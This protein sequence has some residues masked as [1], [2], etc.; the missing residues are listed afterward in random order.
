M[1]CTLVTPSLLNRAGTLATGVLLLVAWSA[2]CTSSLGMDLTPGNILRSNLDT[3]VMAEYTPA[4][5]LVQSFT[6]PDPDGDNFPDLRDII[7]DGDGLVHAYHGTFTPHLNTLDPATST[8]SDRTIAGWSTTNNISYGGVGNFG[9]Y[10]FATDMATGG[11]GTPEGIVRFDLTGGATVRFADSESYQDLTIGGDGLVYGL[12]GNGNTIDVFQPRDLSSVRSIAFDSELQTADVRGIAV[13]S[14]GQI[15][16]AAWDGSIY[17]ADSDGNKVDSISSR[18]GSLTDIDLDNE[19]NLV[20]G[21]RF[22]Q[23]FLTDVLL[24]SITSFAPDT[25]TVHVAFTSPLQVPEPSATA[26]VVTPLVIM[27]LRRRRTQ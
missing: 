16:A 23:V 22:G 19:G 25:D 8:Y 10:V 14:A 15:Y 5:V 9:N 1:N 18:E 24:N 11:A 21:G 7:V 13:S 3:G 12:R 4:G 27:V 26:L 17:A 20:V 6:F 2:M